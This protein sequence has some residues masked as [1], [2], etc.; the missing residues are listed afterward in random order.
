LDINDRKVSLK[1][2]GRPLLDINHRNV[3]KE[4]EN[5]AH[6]PLSSLPTLGIYRGKPPLFSKPENNQELKKLK[7]EPERFDTNN[8]L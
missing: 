4:G 2:Q 5:S 7:T 8:Q 1:A 3:R 6:N